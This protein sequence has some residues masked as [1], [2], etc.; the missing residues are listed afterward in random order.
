MTEPIGI[1][2]VS[3]MQLLREGLE[4]LLGRDARIAINDSDPDVVL[5]DTATRGGSAAV[6]ETAAAMPRARIVALGVSETPDELLPLAEAGI[7]GYVTRE[8]NHREVADAVWRAAHDELDCSPGMASSLLRH[9]RVLA[10]R[11][12]GPGN[13]GV[14]TARE[15]QVVAL[16]EQG[17]SN[18][19]I[20]SR[21]GIELATVKNHVHNILEK[22]HANR[23]GEAVA[24][25][26][27][28]R[29][30]AGI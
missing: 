27:E 11:G 21:L 2:I 22:L 7:S 25:F 8:A 18:K 28:G 13:A 15:R 5:L 26:R 6:R 12:L 14:L 16:I 9:V 4:V 20:A 3:E 10:T 29:Q 30:A 19:Q 23:R 24:R 17:L 1:L